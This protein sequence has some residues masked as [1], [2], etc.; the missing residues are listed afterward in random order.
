MTKALFKKQ[1]MEVFSWIYQNKKTGKNRSVQGVVLYV[2]LYLLVFGML[3]EM[4]WMTADMLCEP[5][6]QAGFAW[7]YFALMGMISV[8]LG[9]FGSVFNT[10]AS[11]YQAKDND[12]LLAMPVLPSRILLIRLSGVFMMGL[13]YELIVMIPAVLVYFLRADVGAVAVIF[14]L[15]IPLVLAILVLTLSAVLGWLVAVISSRL[16]NKNVIVVF[17]SLIFIAL[18]YYVYGRAY[19]ILGM[20]A[21]NPQAVGDKVRSILYPFYHMGLAAEGNMV[22]MLIFTGIVGAFFAL[23]YVILS[24]SFLGI[25][26]SNRGTVKVQYTE[27]FTEKKSISQALLGK[28]LKRFLGSSNYMLNCGLGIVIMIVGAVALLI[29]ADVVRTM[30]HEILRNQEITALI[31]A[32]AICMF[33]SMN[34]ITAPSVSLEGNNLWLVQVFPISAKQVLMAKLK[35]HLILTLVPAAVLTAAVEWVIKPSV[36]FAVM[37]PLA[38]AAF[39]VLMAEFGLFM[40]LKMPNLT[41]TSE[42]VPIKQSLNVMIALFGGW[43]VVVGLAAAYYFL[44]NVLSPLAYLMAATVVIAVVDVILL[45][46]ISGRGARIL[47]TL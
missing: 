41:W 24:R 38:A 47:E 43:A 33:T 13:M 28:E 10:Y 6:V 30:I 2:L 45:R 36:P 27:R 42:I 44:R 46:W 19:Q 1:M 7:L 18:Y 31:A 3:G 26:T 29:K 9:V 12:L 22:S 40:N 37:I 14:T 35:L 23:V 32:A 21:A 20:I 11:L 25:A 17:L 4:F 8:A 5:L 34:D 15:L 39:I 16:K